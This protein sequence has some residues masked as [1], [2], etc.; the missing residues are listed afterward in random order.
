M[1]IRRKRTITK[2]TTTKGQEH[3]DKAT[4]KLNAISFI[5]KH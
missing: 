2:E 3:E 5:Y 1:W 4:E